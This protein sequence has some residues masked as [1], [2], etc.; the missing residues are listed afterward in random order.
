[1]REEEVAEGPIRDLRGVR[2]EEDEEEG[3]ELCRAGDIGRDGEAT[4]DGED[5]REMRGSC[6][7]VLRECWG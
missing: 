4:V 5:D 1:M 7:D 6:C 2:E 3:R